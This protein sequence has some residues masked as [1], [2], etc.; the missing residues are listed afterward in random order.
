MISIKNAITTPFQGFE[1]VVQP[2]D[3]AAVG[4]IDKVNGGLLPPVLH[5]LQELVEAL[6]PTFLNPLDP[7]LDF[8]LGSWFQNRLFKDGRRLLAQV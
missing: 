4:P 7:G 5:G 3:K 6:Q 8:A 2:F 1:L